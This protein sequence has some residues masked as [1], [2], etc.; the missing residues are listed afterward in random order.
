M[1]TVAECEKWFLDCRAKE[2]AALEAA[3]VALQSAMEAKCRSI[4]A[5]HTLDE[6]RGGKPAYSKD[7]V[8]L[9]SRA[10]RGCHK[11]VRRAL[12]VGLLDRI[13]F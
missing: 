2:D 10:Q 4:G 5:L 11:I 6:A 1:R 13:V 9:T 12:Q 7:A 3:V 8:I